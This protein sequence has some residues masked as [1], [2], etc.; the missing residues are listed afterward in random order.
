[1]DGALQLAAH[2]SGSTAGSTATTVNLNNEA[3]FTMGGA[4]GTPTG[5]S[6]NWCNQAR[7]QG[8]RYDE[9]QFYDTALDAEQIG[10]LATVQ[11]T[12]SGQFSF[13]PKLVFAPV[14]NALRLTWP[15]NR[16]GFALQTNSSLLQ[17]NGWGVLSTNYSV[18]S[19]NFAV[20]IS[21]GETGLFYRLSKP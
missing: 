4:N 5:V 17:P 7:N 15:T 18:I 6:F 2:G 1:M 9:V 8:D 13:L 11:T 14:A 20:T 16:V 19:T 12:Y 10:K 3:Q 21:T